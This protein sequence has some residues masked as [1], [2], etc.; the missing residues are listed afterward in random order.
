MDYYNTTKSLL[1]LYTY[2]KKGIFVTNISTQKKFEIM[3]KFILGLLFLG[4]VSTVAMANDETKPGNPVSMVSRVALKNFA[5]QFI[6]ATNVTWKVNEDYQK[7]VFNL[8]GKVACAMYDPEGQFLM[9]SEQVVLSDVPSP[10][11]ADIRAKYP[12]YRISEVVKV[13][14]RPAGYEKQDDIGAYWAA[15]VKDKD[16]VYLVVSPGKS[17]RVVTKSTL[18]K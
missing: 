3:K 18:S 11:V 10:V 15:V 4:A 6:D 17:I 14:A 8:G 7:A 16:I 5:Y 9:A 2:Y 1:K 13:L 12:D